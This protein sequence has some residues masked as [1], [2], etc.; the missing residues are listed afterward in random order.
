MAKGVYCLTFPNGKRYVGISCSK[1]GFKS[2]WN[3]YKNLRCKD[4]PKLYNALK[5]YGSENIKYEIILETDD[6]DR[7]KRVEKQLIALW[8][9]QN[10]KYGY[11]MTPGGDGNFGWVPSKETRKKMSEARK[12]RIIKDSTRKKMSEVR[13]KFKWS[14]EV[15]QKISNSHKGKKKNND[16]LLKTFKFIKNGKLIEITN[17][18]QYCEENNVIYSVMISLHNNKYIC[19]GKLYLTYKGYSKYV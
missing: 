5:K 12:K 8:N 14:D 17:L 10:D 16:H 9:L 3:N 2:R 15:K 19:R 6:K 4:Q 11:N 13:K 7:A 1:Y 18:R